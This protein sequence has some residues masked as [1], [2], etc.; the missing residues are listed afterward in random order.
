MKSLTRFEFDV[1]GDFGGGNIQ[2]DGVISLDDWV[3]VADG[4]TVVGDQEWHA[5]SS[6]LSFLHFAKLVLQNTN[7]KTC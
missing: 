1:I 2:N 6:Q 7:W 5:F 3:W 4:A